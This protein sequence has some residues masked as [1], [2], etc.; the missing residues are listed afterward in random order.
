MV[1]GPRLSLTCSQLG[2]IT[3]YENAHGMSSLRKFISSFFYYALMYSIPRDLPH[4]Q[5]PSSRQYAV[6]DLYSLAEDNPELQ[7]QIFFHV[8]TINPLAQ[9]TPTDLRPE[10]WSAMPCKFHNHTDRSVEE[11]GFECPESI[12]PFIVPWSESCSRFQYDVQDRTLKGVDIFDLQRVIAELGMDSK[13]RCQIAPCVHEGIITWVV[14]K[15]SFRL[16]P[17]RAAP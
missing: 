11:R 7:R 10:P 12:H 3:C 2:P 9:N 16:A 8:R 4:G 1:K 17:P 15:V 6:E 13:E 14:P 5:E